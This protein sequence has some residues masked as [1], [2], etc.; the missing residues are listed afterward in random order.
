[1]PITVKN[2][3]NLG[4]LL[5][6]L[7]DVSR[8]IEGALPELREE[9]I[10]RTRSGRDVDGGAFAPY[11]ERYAERKEQVSP[12]GASPVSLSLSGDMLDS[13][14]ARM[15]GRDGVIRIEGEFNQAKAEYNQGVNARI[16]SRRFMALSAEQMSRLFDRIRRRIFD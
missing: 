14:S 8:V 10:A 16:P 5:E 7:K 15:S 9:I 3:T 6:R 13:M 4:P 2:N 12:F 11:N 1:M